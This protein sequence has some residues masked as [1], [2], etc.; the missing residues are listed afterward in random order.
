MIVLHLQKVASVVRRSS[1]LIC[2]IL[3]IVFAFGAAIPAS[4]ETET[5]VSE[6]DGFTPDFR[7]ARTDS[8]R[9]TLASFIKLR[10]DLEANLATFVTDRSA[11]RQAKLVVQMEQ[12]VSLVDLSETPRA[13]RRDVGIDTANYLLDIFGRVELPNLDDVPDAETFESDKPA[14]YLIPKTPFRIV[15]IDEGAASGEFLFGPRTSRVAPDFARVVAR[16]PLQSSLG[17]SSWTTYLPKLTGWMIPAWLISNIPGP[18]EKPWLDTPVWKVLVVLLIAA[19]IVLLFVSWRFWVSTRRSGARIGH[20]ALLALGPIAALGAF[21][22]LRPFFDYQINLT[23]RFAA[24]VYISVTVVRYFAWTYLLWLAVQFLFEWIIL[25]PRIPDNSLNANM[26]RLFAQIIGLIGGLIV[27][28]FGAQ[29]I[30]LPVFSIL[31]GL[32]I[33]GL[34]FAL[35]IRPTL[36]N[37]IGGFI[38][39][40]DRP[41]DVGDFCEFGD[42]FG[43]VEAIGIRSTQIRDRNRSLISVP[44]AQFADMQIINWARCDKMLILN[45]I[46]LRYETEADQ[47]RYVLTKAREMFLAHPRID[48]ETV[49]VRFVGYGASSLDIEIRAYALAQDLDGL[50]EIREDVMLRLKDI[51]AESGTGFAF[52][53]L[54]MYAT[55][56]GGLDKE[57]TEAAL[58][59][60]AAWR[61]SGD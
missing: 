5:P 39:Y 36:E 27:L 6:N 54:T 13:L 42:R 29:E 48:P 2:G 11:E 14:I 44:N 34:A 32:G 47:L 24:S 35:A 12:L 57:R 45:V 31:A 9:Q 55:E 21:E 7:P 40:L 25:S 52:P 60:V 15:R 8:P 59:T 1:A 22:L 58:E 4:A 46:G 20:L 18:L 43:T 19:I 41:V 56:D 16:L 28:A 49:R 23:G 50:Y 17:I 53:S 51:V 30:G 38:I 33:G 26:L 37:L 61:Q 3:L 10:S